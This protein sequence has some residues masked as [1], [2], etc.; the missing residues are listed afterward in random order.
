M[1]RAAVIPDQQ[2]VLFPSMPVDEF[3]P[4]TVLVQPTQYSVT[5]RLIK[6][7]EVSGKTRIDVEA[8]LLSFRVLYYNRVRT[9]VGAV[10]VFGGEICLTITA[11]RDGCHAEIMHCVQWL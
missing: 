6:A 2:V 8:G 10:E 9:S 11:T 4:L 7:F 1:H 3:G 5:F